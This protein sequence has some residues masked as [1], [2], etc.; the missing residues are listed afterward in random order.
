MKTPIDDFLAIQADLT[1]VER[2]ARSDVPGRTGQ[3]SELIPLSLPQA[4]QQFSFDV[5]L[6]R[7]TGCKACVTAC[8]S[9]NGLDEGESF[10]TVGTLF[11]QL[12]FPQTVTTACHH[13]ADPGC[14]NGCPAE[15]YTKDPV[16]G[17]VKH[18]DDACI[19]C[20]YCTLT[21]PYEV[22]LYNDRLGIVRKCDMC[23]DRLADGEAPACVQGC[24][25]QAISIS[26]VEA[27]PPDQSRSLVAGA[28]PSALSQPTSRYHGRAQSEPTL[29]AVDHVEP[30][31][32]HLPLVVLLVL[33]QL[34]VGVIGAT[35]LAAAIWQLPTTTGAIVGAAMAA[36]AALASVAHLGQP[37][38]AWRVVLGW[39]HS[40][41]SREALLL[42][43]YV[44]IATLATGASVA[45]V[46][47][48]TALLGASTGFGLIAVASS[49]MIYIVT[50]RRYWQTAETASRFATTIALGLGAWLTLIGVAKDTTGAGLAGAA[51]VAAAVVARH[52]VERRVLSTADEEP[53]IGRTRQLLR[54]DLQALVQ[55]RR[56]A[57]SAGAG[58]VAIGAVFAAMVPTVI[59]AALLTVSELI[60]RRLFFAACAPRTMP[61]A[62]R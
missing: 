28:A 33:S 7:C 37:L 34:S 56:Y 22:P 30:S 24:P 8:H 25:T 2:F 15:A 61:Q 59:G 11:S 16:T 31:H 10:R 21:C 62:L 46:A 12:A 27:A 35:A 47:G 50:G 20:Q 45:G 41:L 6:D 54:H 42:G 60:E 44:G 38:K 51:I 36:A 14:L 53:D 23:A 57:L 52:Q 5:D 13:C 18:L 29:E 9:L 55:Q 48:S 3:W 40:W 19:G 4:G 39:S 32:E 43:G 1:A 58:F 26:I 17:I 49:A